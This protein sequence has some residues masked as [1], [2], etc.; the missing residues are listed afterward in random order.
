MGRK[1]SGHEKTA[2]YARHGSGEEAGV[3]AEMLRAA[4]K[5]V[6]VEEHT[7]DIPLTDRNRAPA[8]RAFKAR[9]E[10]SR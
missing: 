3:P 5:R 1:R 8:G 4:I 6:A 7:R 10:H 2:V 9:E